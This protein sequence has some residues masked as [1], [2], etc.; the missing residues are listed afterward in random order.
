MTRCLQVHSEGKAMALQ[1]RWR[2]AEG[3]TKA[4]RWP[5]RC[6]SGRHSK[7]LRRS[8]LPATV[9]QGRARRAHTR[10][11]SCAFTPSATIGSPCRFIM[12]GMEGPCISASIRPTRSPKLAAMLTARL[13]AQ[14]WP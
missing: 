4:G 11:S 13:T 9:I 1:L 10:A 14:R 6:Q 7:A 2:R 8:L 5:V 12:V 3:A